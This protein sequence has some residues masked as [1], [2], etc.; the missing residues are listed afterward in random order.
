MKNIVFLLIILIGSF[1]CVQGQESKD[2]V[3]QLEAMSKLD[4]LIGEWKGKGWV[5]T[6]PD[7][8]E[9]FDQYE[10]VNYKT[11]SLTILIEGKGTDKE[12]P[13][14]ITHDALALIYYDS[15]EDQYNFNSHVMQGYHGSY[16]GEVKQDTFI[17]KIENPY[18]GLIIYTICIDDQDQWFEVGERKSKSGDKIKFFEMTLSKIK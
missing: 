11:D 2:K 16:K 5:M 3:Q 14:K 6:G 17:W 10:T 4:F 9:V 12:N 15:N 18:A 7:K 1:V 8:R 13:K